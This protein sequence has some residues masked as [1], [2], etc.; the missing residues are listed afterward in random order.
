MFSFYCDD[1]G[2]H[3]QSPVAV[4][5]CLVS[6]VNK[7]ALFQKA[8]C[9]VNAAENFGV[10]HMADFEGNYDRFATEEWR[11]TAKKGANP[12]SSSQRYPRPCGVGRGDGSM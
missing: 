4:A 2:T 11:D 3:K 5:A 1:S 6:S 9:E 12:Q 8:W 7:W 10:F